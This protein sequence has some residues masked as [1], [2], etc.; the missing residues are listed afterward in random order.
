[1]WGVTANVQELKHVK[2]LRAT[3]QAFAAILEDGSVVTWGSPYAGGDSSGV[4]ARL[5][6]V[7][8][9]ESGPRQKHSLQFLQTDL[10]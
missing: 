1:M 2:Q 9:V 5:R 10:S 3:P 8:Q 7:K 6:N 4:Q